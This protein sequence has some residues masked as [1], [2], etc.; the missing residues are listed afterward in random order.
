[1]RARVLTL[2]A[3]VAVTLGGSCGPSSPR[4]GGAVRATSTLATPTTAAD[5]PLV[6]TEAE[7]GRSFTLSAGQTARLRLS[8]TLVWSS[9][10]VGG[11][12]ISLVPVASFA[13]TGAQEWDV[14]AVRPGSAR[15][16]STGT[17]NCPPAAPCPQLGRAF[18]VS[19]TV[20]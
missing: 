3:L 9:P 20:G 6:I 10:Q 2:A 12:A 13:A 11:D 7:S 8:T 14:V 18:D 19:V 5:V 1:M 16:T 15:V 17:P 4:G